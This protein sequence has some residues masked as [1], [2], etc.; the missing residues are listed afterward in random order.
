M[1]DVAYR[2]DAVNKKP[3]YDYIIKH[4]RSWLDFAHASGRD[5]SQSDLIL[6]DG[7][8]RTS[9]WACAAW[10]GKGP[11]K[12]SFVV[13]APGVANESAGLWGRWISPQSLDKNV[14]PRPLVPGVEGTV[15][16][17]TLSG[18]ILMMSWLLR[19]RLPR[20]HRWYHR[21][22]LISACSCVVSK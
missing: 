10:S 18:A 5:V 11:V 17:L 14:G 13:G 20:S 9:E 8:D 16:Q 19:K 12:F 2:Q 7:C 6:V 21:L 3:F 15:L 22:H 4:H 1:R